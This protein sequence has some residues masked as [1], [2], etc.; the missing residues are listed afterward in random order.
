MLSIAYQYEDQ[1]TLRALIT[2]H[3][4]YILTLGMSVANG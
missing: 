1:V 2:E 3:S 4:Q